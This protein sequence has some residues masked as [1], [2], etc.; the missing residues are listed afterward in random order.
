MK[1]FLFPVLFGQY[2]SPASWLV[3]SA[4]A[5]VMVLL[6][7][8]LAAPSVNAACSAPTPSSTYYV[9]CA[10]SM[11]GNGTMESKWNNLGSAITFLANNKSNKKIVV[12]PRD[13]TI[14]D[15]FVLS[16]Q[17]NISIESASPTVPF[18]I[19]RATPGT[20]FDAFRISNDSSN[21]RIKG[22]RI[23]AMGTSSELKFRA[24]ITL[25]DE[26]T[27]LIIEDVGISAATRLPGVELLTSG[28]SSDICFVNV[29]VDNAGREGDK[30]NAFRIATTGSLTGLVFQGA[31]GLNSKVGFAMS[32]SSG[33]SGAVFHSYVDSNGKVTNT[34]ASDNTAGGFVVRGGTTYMF[35]VTARN[36]GVN[37]NE[38][39]G[40]LIY[41]SAQIENAHITGNPFGIETGAAGLVRVFGSTIAGNGYGIWS[42]TN[43]EGLQVHN[44]IIAENSAYAVRL[45]NSS[46]SAF[47]SHNLIR[48]GN[49]DGCF[50]TG[51]VSGAPQFN[52]AALSAKS[53]LQPSSPARNT[54]RD[55]NAVPTIGWVWIG[56]VQDHDGNS[57]PQQTGYEMGAFEGDP[58]SIPTPGPGPDCLGDCNDNG[59]VTVAELISAVNISLGRQPMAVCLNADA[60]SDDRVSIS[61]LVTAVINNLSGCSTDLPGSVSPSRVLALSDPH[62]NR[63]QS[64]PV[65]VS[66]SSNDVAGLQVDI[67]VDSAVA[68][69]IDPDN[70]CVLASGLSAADYILVSTTVP[71]G[72]TPSGKF[73]LR[74]EIIGGDNNGAVR[75]LPQGV[76]ATC[77]LQVASNAPFALHSLTT[78]TVELCNGDADVFQN[79]TVDEG[80]IEVCDGCCP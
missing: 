28:T 79:V 16:N 38:A 8:V 74:L 3:R 20:E 62:G 25:V 27:N 68:T 24:G 57:R 58:G 65:N 37:D 61:E 54:G 40:I 23:L 66:V 51:D 55:P 1:G 47:C 11:N 50:G 17:T 6:G 30:R 26:I 42:K 29:S 60:N 12:E 44:S 33:I 64:V 18:S 49:N 75:T 59:S 45:S 73:G 48:D 53:Y 72:E 7:L 80:S 69:A 76:V 22:V 32:E 35:D 77:T 78:Q 5:A 14:S 4:T 70:D 10:A 39:A 19:R 56:R 67:L 34:E 31:R 21:I 71:S 36:N 2:S 13:C 63:G 41:D 15:T 9:D 46:G 43:T 52:T